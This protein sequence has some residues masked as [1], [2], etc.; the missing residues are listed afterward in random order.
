MTIL[1]LVIVQKMFAQCHLKQCKIIF[2]ITHI[3]LFIYFCLVRTFY[4]SINQ[5]EVIDSYR[6]L[7]LTTTE[8]T[9]FKHNRTQTKIG[10][11]PPPCVSMPGETHFLLP[12]FWS[13]TCIFLPWPDWKHPLRKSHMNCVI[14]VIV[15]KAKLNALIF[16]FKTGIVR[17]RDEWYNS[18]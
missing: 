12:A 2:F 3:P 4:T 5:T 7:Y 18:C 11:P 16:A 15:H 14:S 8:Y 9:F 17:Y 10:P 13:L 1:T 6:T